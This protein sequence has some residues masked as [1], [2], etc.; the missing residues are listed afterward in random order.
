MS[1]RPKPTVHYMSGIEISTECACGFQLGF[2]PDQWSS[3]LCDVT[4]EA[5]TVALGG[6]KKT[7]AEAIAKAACKIECK[8]A[9]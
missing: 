8:G 5:C 2:A 4:C 3:D 1:E 9:P 6:V 7:I